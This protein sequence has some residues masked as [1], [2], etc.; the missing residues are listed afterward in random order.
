LLAIYTLDGAG[1]SFE[2]SEKFRKIS[3]SS[4]YE[5]G[6]FRVDSCERAVRRDGK[7]LLLT[8]KVFDILL[9]LI[10]NPGRILTKDEMMQT[11][12]STHF[13]LP[14]D[15]KNS[16]RASDSR[17]LD[18][19]PAQVVISGASCLQEGQTLPFRLLQRLLA[20]LL[21]PLKTTGHAGPKHFS[22]FCLM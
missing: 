15:S 19:F 14:A 8:P 21:N 5:F 2:S 18:R 17:I 13:A 22:K 4:T 6:P 11:P 3:E 12:P 20:Q 9:V 16:W 1:K 7:L 10:Q